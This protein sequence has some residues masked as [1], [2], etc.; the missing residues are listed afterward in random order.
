M[1]IN[2]SLTMGYLSNI[3]ITVNAS[4]ISATGY[5]SYKH[6]NDRWDRRLVSAASV[7]IFALISG[8]GLVLKL[9]DSFVELDLISKFKVTYIK[10]NENFNVIHIINH[11]NKIYDT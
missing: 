4:I 3:I 6:W 9:I 8:Q 7:T 5:L 11:S 10:S 2:R 1:L